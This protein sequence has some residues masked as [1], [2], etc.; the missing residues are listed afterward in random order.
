MGIQAEFLGIQFKLTEELLRGLSSISLK[1]EA[2]TEETESRDGLPQIDVIGFEP[3]SLT[4]DYKAHSG[5]GVDPLE[6][7]RAWRKKLG[8]SG[9]FY[10][11][12]D[13]YGVDV[14][15][16]MNV[17][18]SNTTLNSAGQILTGTITLQLAQDIVVTEK[19]GV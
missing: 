12:G 13:Q 11:G 7:Y 8:E 14:F 16:L 15:I 17:R 3:Q 1:T 19:K 9:P 2:K 18:L 6:E 5:M 4:I 10:L